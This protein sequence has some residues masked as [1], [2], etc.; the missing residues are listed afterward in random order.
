[1]AGE[2][3]F[4]RVLLS[5]PAISLAIALFSLVSSVTQSFNYARNIDSV[6]RNVLRAE[7]LRTC[8][9][10]IDVFFQL[11]L[12]A[13]ETNRARGNQNDMNMKVLAYKFGALGTFLAN[14]RDEDVR[15]RYTE[16]SF[17]LLKVATEAG[18]VS[19]ADFQALYARVDK[20]FGTINDDCARTAHV[21]LL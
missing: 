3:G 14:F 10:I 2:R 4:L 19:E 8:K 12:L 6:Q 18:S 1:L 21:K 9:E 17:D 16:L 13:E 15:R 7:N 5:L 20:N 11:R